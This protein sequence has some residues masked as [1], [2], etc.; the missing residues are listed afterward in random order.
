MVIDT[1]TL[2]NDPALLKQ[3][4]VDLSIE[5]RVKD[6]IIDKGKEKYPQASL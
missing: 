6:S 1:K 2:P 3:I 5:N 4:I